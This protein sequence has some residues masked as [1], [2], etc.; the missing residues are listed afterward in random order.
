[1]SK[2]H[3]VMSPSRYHCQWTLTEYLLWVYQRECKEDQNLDLQGLTIWGQ[4]DTYIK[5]IQVVWT[6]GS[7]FYFILCINYKISLKR[8]LGCLARRHEILDQKQRSLL[9]T[10]QQAST[11]LGKSTAFPVR[12]KLAYSLSKGYTLLISQVTSCINKREK[13]P[14]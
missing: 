5:A 1:M 6:A 4:K 8:F 12:G 9:L 7:G 11:E 3:P 2:F 14:G 10:A 13:W